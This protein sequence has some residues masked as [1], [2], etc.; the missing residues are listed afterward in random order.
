MSVLNSNQLHGYKT[1]F[2]FESEPQIAVAN[3]KS[4]IS[5]EYEVW[6][7]FRTT[8][9]IT[10][11]CFWQQYFQ[12]FAWNLDKLNQSYQM[13]FVR[14]Q[15]FHFFIANI[16]CSECIDFISL[17]SKLRP[18]HWNKLTFHNFSSKR[19]YFFSKSCILESC[20]ILKYFAWNFPINIITICTGFDSLV[21]TRSKR[22]FK[23][24][25]EVFKL[26]ISN[27][28]IFC[29]LPF[30]FLEK[31][32]YT[33]SFRK[34]TKNIPEKKNRIIKTKLNT[35][36][37]KCDFWRCKIVWCYITSCERYFYLNL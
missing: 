23:V 25:Y 11:R 6:K 13:Y 8:V 2:V 21:Q 17:L 26:K 7:V 28:S 9:L 24:S 1:Y 18:F 33:Y 32:N 20:P 22:H 37:K 19:A 35:Q 36:L 34:K 27:L 29:Y 4:N 31:I 15:K 10:L 16:W 12:N 5:D 30:D 3:F 14:G